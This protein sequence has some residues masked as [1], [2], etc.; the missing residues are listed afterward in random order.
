MVS[1]L[2]YDAISRRFVFGDQRGRKLIV[3]DERSNQPVDLVRADSAGFLDI[4]A[5]EIDAKRGDLWVASTAAADGAAAGT[6]HRL[7]LVSGRLLRAFQV[8]ADLEPVKLVDL[9]VNPAGAVLVLDS[10]TPQLLVLRAGGTALERV[11]RIEAQEPAS[12]STGGVDG[13]AFVAHREG[14]SRIDLRSR[15]V[16][17]VAAP[18]GVSLGHL[19]RIRWGGDAL[20][21]VQLDVDG[22]RRIVRLE[23]NAS[24][25]AITKATRLEV[26]A[27]TAGQTF[28]TIS[29]DEL[30]YLMAGSYEACGRPLSDTS[31]TPE[32]FVVYRVPLR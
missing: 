11:V 1:G 32:D 6:L 9:A 8:G 25:S 16:T 13:I 28:V 15:T 31:S 17:P 3:V 4:S 18:K 14:I 12:V 5:V 22:S 27:P 29:G 19:E 23:M 10:L 20:I 26:S 21:A 24:G 7:Q 30:V 2:A